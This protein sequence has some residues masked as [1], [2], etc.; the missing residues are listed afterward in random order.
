[1]GATS[2]PR[3]TSAST[4]LGGL[5]IAGFLDMSA[6]EIP[7]KRQEFQDKKS[8]EGPA[9]GFRRIAGA[10]GREQPDDHADHA[11]SDE[12]C[13]EHGEIDAG[14]GAAGQFIADLGRKP[15]KG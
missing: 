15:R 4:G 2:P 10:G 7:P 13:D 8:T 3:V 5:S 14:I 1:G 12:G 6:E 9:I 11:L